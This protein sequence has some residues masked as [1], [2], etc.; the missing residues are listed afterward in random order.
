MSSLPKESVW[1]SKPFHTHCRHDCTERP[2][3]HAHHLH[4]LTISLVTGCSSGIGA[5]ICKYVVSQGH[6]LVAT[7]RKVEALSYLQDSPSI[8]KLPLD[9]TSESARTAALNAA[10]ERFGRID[11]LCNN[12]GYGLAGD[13]ESLTDQQMRNQLETNFWSP[14]SLTREAVRIFREV[15]PKSGSIGGIVVQVSSI[16]GRGAFP[17]NAL[18]HAS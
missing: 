1:F 6:R 4:L 15:N 8:L 2:V 9:V 17:G 3:P 10:L 16:G 13:T 14:L 18:Y 11:V 12:A 5:D 7:A